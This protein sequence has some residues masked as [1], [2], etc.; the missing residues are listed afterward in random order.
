MDIVVLNK[1][2][3]VLLS[4]YDLILNFFL[5][6]NIFLIHFWGVSSFKYTV[7]ILDI[8]IIEN[9]DMWTVKYYYAMST[10][11]IETMSFTI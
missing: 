6:L 8:F 3:K 11:G 5:T 1:L 7:F 4:I 2:F 9:Y 10:E